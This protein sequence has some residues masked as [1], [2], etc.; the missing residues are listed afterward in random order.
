[1]K[2]SPLLA[3]L[4]YAACASPNAPEKKDNKE[5][6]PVSSAFVCDSVY[7]AVRCDSDTS[8]SYS[9]LLPYNYQAH[10]NYPV[11]LFLDPHADGALPLT[12]YRQQ[13]TKCDAILLAS[14]NSK[15]GIPLDQSALF[16]KQ[17]L[18]DAVL[19]TSID[20]NAVFLVGFSGGARVAGSV[21]AQGFPAAGIIACSAGIPNSTAL[22]SI[23]VCLL[24]GIDDANLSEMMRLKEMFDQQQT[25]ALFM[26]FDSGHAW[27]PDTVM[28]L[29][30]RYMLF[31]HLGT[32][33]PITWIN[34][35]KAEFINRAEGNTAPVDALQLNALCAERKLMLFAADVGLEDAY[36]KLDAENCQAG[37]VEAARLKWK[38]FLLAEE[39]QK[40]VYSNAV[41]L[42]NSDYWRK[43]IIKLRQKKG[44]SADVMHMNKRLQGWLG[45]I[46]Y[47]LATRAVSSGDAAAEELVSVYHL[48]EP[49]NSEA[50]YLQAVLMARQQIAPELVLRQ[51]KRAALDGFQ[52]RERLVNQIEF[53][54][55]FNTPGFMDVLDNMR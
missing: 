39:Q 14:N 12:K 20:E 13:A 49:E 1:M 10:K 15:N 5:S 6:N 42:Q 52:E 27:C 36:T 33:V 35:Y 34:D 26:R 44:I 23:P 3:F 32:K 50:D 55:Y 37:R 30:M 2:T 46:L 7:A 41:G 40:Q 31:Q 47:S 4:I 29:A 24:A 48:L 17:I 9:M 54:A 18:H 25:K 43:E 38:Q 22:N 45:L 53:K 28:K 16:I 51:L 8:I 11:F 21:I 19:K